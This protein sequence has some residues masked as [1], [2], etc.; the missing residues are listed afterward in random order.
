MQIVTICIQPLKG[1]KMKTLIATI[2]SVFA[3]SAMAADAPKAP[4][5][6]KEVTAQP[7]P[8][9]S[10]APKEHKKADTKVEAKAPAAK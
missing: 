5:A 8:H 4:E 1:N 6:K 2:M 9:K 7:A 10:E 3:L